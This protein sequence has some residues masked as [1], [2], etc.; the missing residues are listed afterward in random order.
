LLVLASLAACRPAPP[1][2][3]LAPIPPFQMLDQSGTPFGAAQLQG[4]P[5]VADFIYTECKDSC[6]QLTARMADLQ[7][8][9]SSSVQLVTFTVDPVR[10]TPAKLQAYASS[11]GADPQR[12]HF[13]TGPPDLVKYLL[14]TGFKVTLLD[15]SEKGVRNLVHDEHLVL[16][17]KI[18]RVRGYYEAESGAQKR[19]RRDAE[20]LLR[21]P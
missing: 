17:D 14:G 2:P 8:R 7:K 9:L 1:P 13:L 5:W 15:E 21:E 3:V 20:T 11:A 18:G 10:D 16:I 4:R 19:L 6:P 12:W